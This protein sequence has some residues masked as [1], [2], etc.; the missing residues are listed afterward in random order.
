MSFWRMIDSLSDH[1]K[2]NGN[3]ERLTVTDPLDFQFRE[4]LR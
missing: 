1:R 2:G 3:A 4:S